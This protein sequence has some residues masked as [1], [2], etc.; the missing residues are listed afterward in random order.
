MKKLIRIFLLGLVCSFMILPF[1]LTNASSR[2]MTKILPNLQGKWYDLQGNPVLD[3]EK[4]TLNGC[5][6]VDMLN[7]AGGGG[8]FNIVVRIVEDA[9]YRDLKL[10]CTGISP[11]HNAYHQYIRLDH[12]LLRRF[13]EARY[14]ETIGG[15]GLGMTKQDVLGRYGNPDVV[16][17]GERGKREFWKYEAIGLGIEWENGIAVNLQIYKDG[18][19]HFDSNGFN[20]L[21]SPKEYADYYGWDRVPKAGSYGSYYIGYGEYLWFRYYPD[22]VELNLYPN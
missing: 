18:D 7:P 5:Q 16:K 19:R 2:Y 22:M 10:I 14:H 9:G 12:Q 6:I 11:D 20:A 15:L 3:F 21:N 17:N 8:N 4:E 1:S 13:P